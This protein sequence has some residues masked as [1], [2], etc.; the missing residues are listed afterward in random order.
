MAGLEVP[1]D[2]PC[3]TRE[4]SLAEGVDRF[5]RSAEDQGRQLARAGCG[6]AK[7]RNGDCEMELRSVEAVVGAR[8]IRLETLMEMKRVA[9]RLKD[10]ADL[11]ALH[12]LDPYKK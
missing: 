5:E 12:K 11:D 10:L 7:G 4:D 2:F 1:C 8:I 6:N 3:D 9:N